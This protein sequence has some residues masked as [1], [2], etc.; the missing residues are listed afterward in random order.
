MPDDELEW[1]QVPASDLSDA[2]VSR[3]PVPGGWLYRVEHLL[4]YREVDVDGQC[5]WKRQ[6]T[7]TFVPDLT[8]DKQ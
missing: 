6:H 8:R 2:V 1:E 4:P 5:H 7:V 3:L